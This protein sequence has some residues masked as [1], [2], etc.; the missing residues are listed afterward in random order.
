MN[1]KSRKILSVVCSVF[2]LTG[3]IYNYAYSAIRMKTVEYNFGCHDGLNIPTDVAWQPPYVVVNLPDANGP[4]AIKNAFVEVEYLSSA[5]V[6][7]DV[8]NIDIQFSTGIAP[9]GLVDAMA[10]LMPDSSGESN[11]MAVK[12]DVTAKMLAWADQ[13]YSMKIIVTG[14][15]SNMH[16]AKLYITYEYDDDAPTQVKTVRF[17][18]FSDSADGISGIASSLAQQVPGSPI[19]FKY[20]A[21]LPDYSGTPSD[22]QQ[23]WFEIRGYKQDTASLVTGSI[24]VQIAG[25]NPDLSMVLDR[26]LNDSYRFRYLSSTNVPAGFIE[27]LGTLQILDVTTNGGAYIN[28]LGGEAVI[29]YQFSNSQPTKI[30]TINY[31]LGQSTGTAGGPADFSAPL[32]LSEDGVE[33]KRIYALVS[34]SLDGASLNE[35]VT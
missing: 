22:I 20:R 3:I 23:A 8:S 19:H 27:T 33:I 29:T 15:A 28:N 1:I 30:K 4:A 10:G 18:V 32:Y 17:P 21:D 35:T 6:A 34:G 13:S 14:P 25:Y 7:R 9:G 5:G 24:T 31:F 12:A 26:A 11:L 16:S 2:C